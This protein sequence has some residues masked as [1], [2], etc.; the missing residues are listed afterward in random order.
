MN[1]NDF[2]RLV[3]NPDHIAGIY[4]YCDRWCERCAFTARCANF[5]VGEALDS[6][7]DESDLDSDRLWNTLH[8][9]FRLT[10]ELLKESAGDM[11]IDLEAQDVD[12]D[13]EEEEA[14]FRRVRRSPIGIST[15][16]YLRMVDSWFEEAGER[17]REKGQELARIASA[18][19]DGIDPDDEMSDLEDCVEVIRWYHMQIH[20]KMMRAMEGAEEEE[21]PGYPRDADGSAK[22]ALIGVDRSIGAWS[23]V[24]KHHFP[25][26]EDAFLPILR[27]LV[28]IREQIETA[29]P[30]AR[31]F[32]RPGFDG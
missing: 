23:H 4:N 12:E 32:V 2:K 13:G 19:L 20:V 6:E 11:G 18:D 5:A 7:N 21:E 26:D 22:V 30:N 29:F 28:R 25:E 10:M 24:W 16:A 15:M 3:D 8:E 31:S 9:S 1:T 27:H 17:F 14:S